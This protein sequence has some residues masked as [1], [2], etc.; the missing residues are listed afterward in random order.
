MVKVD[1][2]RKLTSW[3][4]VSRIA[5]LKVIGSSWKGKERERRERVL[6]LEFRVRTPEFRSKIVSRKHEKCLL[7]KRK[8]FLYFL[9]FYKISLARLIKE[10]K[11]LF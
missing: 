8:S 4:E 10:N 3:V 5:F 1:N 6:E 2:G 11:V 7:C 9:I